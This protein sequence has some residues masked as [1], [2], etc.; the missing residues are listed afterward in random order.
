MT[1]TFP[2]TILRLPETFPITIRT[3]DQAPEMKA[4][5]QLLTMS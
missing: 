1:L 4:V 5:T 2:S 3:W